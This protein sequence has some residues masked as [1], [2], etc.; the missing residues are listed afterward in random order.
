[1]SFLHEHPHYF[2]LEHPHAQVRIQKGQQLLSFLTSYYKRQPND[3]E[4]FTSKKWFLKRHYALP[5]TSDVNITW[6]VPKVTAY[7][8][9]IEHVYLINSTTD[10]KKANVTLQMHKWSCKLAPV[11]IVKAT[12]VICEGVE[13]LYSSSEEL[14]QMRKRRFFPPKKD[15]SP[16]ADAGVF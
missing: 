10:T 7:E 13:L 15:P 14:I 11:P 5:W 3:D 2:T 16:L 12:K 1:M 8:Y 9:R 6:L 4:S